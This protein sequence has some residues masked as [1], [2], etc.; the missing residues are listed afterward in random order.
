MPDAIPGETAAGSATA[1]CETRALWISPFDW[2]NPL[3]QRN[4]LLYL[5]SRG[6]L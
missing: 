1:F 6:G 5:I 4:R 2:G 3:L